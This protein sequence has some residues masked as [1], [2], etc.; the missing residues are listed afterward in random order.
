VDETPTTPFHIVFEHLSLVAGPI[1]VPFHDDQ[2]SF[3]LR[4]A[5]G[6]H[7]VQAV[8]LYCSGWVGPV[9]KNLQISCQLEPLAL[10]LFEPYAQRSA[11]IRF[12]NMTLKLTSQWMAKVNAFEAR[13]QLELG[14]LSEGDLSARG[15]TILDVG[16]LTDG[17]EPR[18]TGEIRVHGPLDQPQD[19][20]GQFMPGDAAAQKLVNQLLERKIKVL[21]V[22]FLGGRMK[23]RIAPASETAMMDIQAVSKEISEALDI[24]ATP[25]VYNVPHDIPAP[26]VAPLVP[27]NITP[28]TKFAPETTS[29]SAPLDQA[30]G[31]GAP[32]PP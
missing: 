9:E 11:A 7:G 16:Q 10:A 6:G 14:N 5:V 22:P 12:Y 2:P 30:E 3:A 27:L 8:P 25:A 21:K 4:G 20:N 32:A 23:I 31:T 28:E 19:W 18:L 29:S 15:R 13:M 24:L 1:S 26:Q 17:G